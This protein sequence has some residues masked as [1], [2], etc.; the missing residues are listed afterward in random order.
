MPDEFSARCQS[1]GE[2][3]NKLLFQADRRVAFVT[4]C[5]VLGTLARVFGIERRRVHEVMDGV[6][7]DVGVEP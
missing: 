1:L 5:G 3:I 6:M 4:V 7:D 2:E